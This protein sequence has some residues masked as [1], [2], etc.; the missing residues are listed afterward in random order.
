MQKVTNRGIHLSQFKEP[1]ISAPIK[2]ISNVNCVYLPVSDD[3][4]VSVSQNIKKG[5]LVSN[6][7]LPE[8][9]AS[10]ASIN[11]KAVAVRKFN[12]EKFKDRMFLK[13]ESDGTN[14]NENIDRF[15]GREVSD[16]D[17]YFAVNYC[18]IINLTDKQPLKSIFESYP[19]G[20][21]NIVI[22][23][24]DDEPYVS[25]KI[26]Q[27]LFRKTQ[28]EAAVNAVQRLFKAQNVEI[29][30]YGKNGDVSIKLPSKIG[31][32]PVTAY[33]KTY[34]VSRAMKSD[35][36]TVYICL[37]AAMSLYYAAADKK[38]WTSTIV[39]VA[40][41]A[42]LEPCNIE[43]P[44]GTSIGDIL[45]FCGVKE[46]IGTVVLGGCMTG[47]SVDILDIPVLKS[48]K[49]I[50]AFESE[51]K[52]TSDECIG[53]GRC[54]DVC[55]ENLLPYYIYRYYLEGNKERL[56]KLSADKCIECGCCSYICPAKIDLRQYIRNSRRALLK[57]MRQNEE[58]TKA[59]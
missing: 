32:Y 4:C 38:A 16:S 18:G 28:V 3:I 27:L 40:G 23:A 47:Y 33:N 42:V 52:Y 30:V 56:Y 21:K 25:S 54:V 24:V 39:T 6:E 50:L 14:Q 26:S 34:P 7:I 20:V 31:K 11:G 44:I 35:E 1:A 53:C 8:H 15:N 29:A 46:R 5:D 37:S 43:V 9:I 36:D 10:F 22:D 48:T 45:S 17:L 12:C 19:D 57:E 55:P 59:N 41:D 51:L 58:D 13:V 49:A 2:S